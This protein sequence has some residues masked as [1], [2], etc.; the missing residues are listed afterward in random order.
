MQSNKHTVFFS[1]CTLLKLSPPAQANHKY[2]HKQTLPSNPTKLNK[3]LLL[4][5]FVLPYTI[6]QSYL[7][8]YNG[9][10]RIEVANVNALFGHINKVVDGL[11]TMLLL[12]VLSHT[13]TS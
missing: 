2:S 13:H 4:F 12:Q 5:V 7:L 11:D 10:E 8:T 1:R 6:P 9:H 3:R